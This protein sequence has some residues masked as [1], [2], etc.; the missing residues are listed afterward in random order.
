[1]PRVSRILLAFVLMVAS[2]ALFAQKKEKEDPNIRTLQGQVTDGSSK[3]V[4][5][6]VVLLKD[7]KT[8]QVR[9]FV[10]QARGDYR[11]AG[12]R[13]DTDYQVRAELNG[14]MSETRRLTVFDSRKLATIDLKLGK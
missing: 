3:A 1:V 7:M 5:G 8:L 13:T 10:T 6:A 14:M 2:A 9:S 4:V 12:L 11:F